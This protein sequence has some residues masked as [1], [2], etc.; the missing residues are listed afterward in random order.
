MASYIKIP[1]DV[2]AVMDALCAAGYEAFLVG[3]CVRDALLGAAPSDY[4]VATN[5]T[6]SDMRRVFADF[7]CLYHG[8]KHGTIAVVA[9]TQTVEVT[10]YRVDGAYSDGRRPDSVSFTRALKDDLMRRDFTVNALAYSESTGL[11][12]EVGGLRDL[13]ARVIRSVGDAKVR[14]HEDALRILRALRFSS[15]LDFSLEAE[16]L[17]AALDMRERLRLISRERI[18]VELQ[19]LLLGARAEAVL[20]VGRPVLEAC[21]S[22]F[23]G[24]AYDHVCKMI[25]RVP[26]RAEARLAAFFLPLGRSAMA[27][28]RFSKAQMDAVDCRIQAFSV[29]YAAPLSLER[30]LGRF[31]LEAVLDALLMRA[32]RGEDTALIQARARELIDENACLTTSQLNISGDDIISAGVSPGARVGCVLST[33][34]ACVMEGRL[35]NDRSA[36]LSAVDQILLDQ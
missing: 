28:L 4:D 33:L 9:K 19:K 26:A 18:Q 17:R 36:L 2:G 30:A 23:T 11:V 15:M 21:V 13:D 16:T 22:G 5:A 8:E 24:D 25:G 1:V 12:D 10:T 3:G 14:Y 34:L 32:A 31:G 29:D 20:E 7:R 27:A 6:P 35:E